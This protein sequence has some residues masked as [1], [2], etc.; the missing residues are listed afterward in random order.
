[1]TK[2]EPQWVEIIEG[3]AKSYPPPFQRIE[4]ETR[5]RALYQRST[6]YTHCFG[7]RTGITEVTAYFGHYEGKTLSF[8]NILRW[9]SA[10]ERFAGDK[11]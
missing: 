11:S 8:F 2:K 9:R 10:P 6:E 1:M 4:I 5:P 3:D 7:R